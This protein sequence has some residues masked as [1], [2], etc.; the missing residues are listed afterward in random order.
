M[1]ITFSCS[2]A[3]SIRALI[4]GSAGSTRAGKSG[5][6]IAQLKAQTGY[7]S[8]NPISTASCHLAAWV[9]GSLCRPACVCMSRHGTGFPLEI[10]C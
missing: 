4:T 10:L 6:V 1:M 8:E 2:R 7:I 3:A 9:P 5:G